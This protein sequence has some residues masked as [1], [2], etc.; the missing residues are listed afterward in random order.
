M[1]R[2]W[3][4][5]GQTYLNLNFSRG[6]FYKKMKYLQTVTTEQLFKCYFSYF[7]SNFTALINAQTDRF[8]SCGF[9]KYENAD[10]N[11]FVILISGLEDLFRSSQ[12]DGL[13]NR[14][15]EHLRR[16][17]RQQIRKRRRPKPVFMDPTKSRSNENYHDIQA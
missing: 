17:L 13:T 3:K 5:F 8:L 11:S 15:E 14:F 10:W 16:A 6:H 9:P 4:F 1:G 7:S 2:F 12:S